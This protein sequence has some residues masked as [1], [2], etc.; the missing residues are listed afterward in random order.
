M[1]S[2]MSLNDKIKRGAEDS[3][4]YFRYMAEFVGFTQADADAINE[5]HLIIEKYIPDIVSRF[6]AQLL[7]Y[8]PTR[9][10]FLRADGSLD[11][12]YLQLRMQHLSNFW[13]RTA[14]GVYDDDYARYVDYVGRAHTERGADPHIYIP[15][16]Y[17]IGQVGFMQ[18]AVSQAI[19]RE[20]HEIDPD[21]EVRALRAWNLLM[22]VILEMLSRAYG[23]E[24]EPETY[25]EQ[26]IVD[27]DP[28]FQLAV[29][30]YELGLGMRTTIE[31]R[32][33]VAGSESE[34]PDGERKI[35]K[36]EG[37]S[38]GVFHHEGGWYALRNSCQH[39]GGPV[40]TGELKDGILTCPLHG[41]QY[42]VTDGELLSD[43]SAHLE[44]Y[45][46]EVRD[47]EV[48]LKIPVIQRDDIQVSIV[49]PSPK[50]EDTTPK[51]EDAPAPRPVLQLNEFST[52]ALKPGR[53]G[54]V[55]VEGE[56]VAVYNVA[57]VFYATHNACTHEGGPMDEGALEG[58][59]ATCPWHGSCF[60]VTSGAVTC[61]PADEPLRTYW[62]EVDG[63]VG[64][65][66][67]N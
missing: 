59:I 52:T 57:G 19:S 43:P 49:E 63:A 7:R 38:I 5:S 12:D 60:D 14:S 62:V 27:H 13:R 45:P 21:W 15:E 2:S 10:Y 29:E 55:E 48:H 64:R 3:G 28:V 6:Y 47:G 23:H 16:R 11:Q 37:L 50:K 9:K 32:D 42:R 58:K 4:R 41:Y 40:A 44:M 24:K 22:M 8:P 36:V 51:A 33:V 61:G 56:L 46:V 1:D 30:A 20:L 39:R 66:F 31:S 35:I 54:L 25:H 18:H 53:I 65:V 34:I 67:P 26:A 17:V